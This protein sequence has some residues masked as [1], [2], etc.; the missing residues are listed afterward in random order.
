M[1]QP[2]KALFWVGVLGI[3]IA[4]LSVPIQTNPVPYVILLAL[5][6]Y[7]PYQQYQTG[8]STNPDP[9]ETTPGE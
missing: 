8:K 2:A 3:M 4:L 1:V 7:Y 5:T 6:A 9:S